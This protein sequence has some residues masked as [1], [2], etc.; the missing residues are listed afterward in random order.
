[1]ERTGY[2]E[3]KKGDTSNEAIKGTFLKWV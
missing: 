1:M 2:E 3:N